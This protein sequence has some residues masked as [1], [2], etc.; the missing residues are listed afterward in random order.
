[1]VLMAAFTVF[2]A[3]PATAFA[4]DNAKEAETEVGIVA[5]ESVEAEVSSKSAPQESAVIMAVDSYLDNVSEET[6]TETAE[7]QTEV[8]V[9]TE[10]KIEA[11]QATEGRPSEETETTA[12]DETA[13]KAEAAKSNDP[14]EKVEP[15]K[16]RIFASGLNI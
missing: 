8:S 7:S 12:E 9:Q 4:A 5:E 6:E 14:E 10:Q 13:E 11:A 1:M 2:Q 16:Q 15:V 3:M